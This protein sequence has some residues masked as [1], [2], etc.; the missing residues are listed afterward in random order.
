PHPDEVVNAQRELAAMGKFEEGVYTFPDGR[1]RD[2]YEAILE[3]ITGQKIEYPQARLN[4]YVVMR[5]TSF[6]WIDHAGA[7]G[8]RQK[9]LAYFFETGPNIKLVQID[10]GA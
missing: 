5:S 7:R 8:V 2:A 1:K 10:K 6:P 9:H 3:R 4:S